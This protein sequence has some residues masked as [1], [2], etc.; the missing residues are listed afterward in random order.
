MVDFCRA[1]K[2]K[3]RKKESKEKGKDEK[4]KKET[5]VFGQMKKRWK[6]DD[7]NRQWICPDSWHI[8]NDRE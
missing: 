4:N 1:R 2:G 5:K 7:S 6:I 8:P 3:K